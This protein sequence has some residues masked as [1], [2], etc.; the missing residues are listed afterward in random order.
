MGIE[1]NSRSRAIPAQS[2]LWT[3]LWVDL[4]GFGLWIG[5]VKEGKDK[6]AD[7][8]NGGLVFLI[9]SDSVSTCMAVWFGTLFFIRIKL[10]LDKVLFKCCH[11]CFWFQ[12]EVILVP[13]TNDL[14]AGKVKQRNIWLPLKVVVIISGLLLIER[15]ILKETTK[16]IRKFTIFE[17]SHK[18]GL[19]QLY[20]VTNLENFVLFEQWVSVCIEIGSG[21]NS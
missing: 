20:E 10:F 21:K 13:T 5:R 17:L 12:G 4:G 11:I 7:M 2:S 8:E 15:N 1:R 6:E 14:T 18:D 19:V 3:H 9:W 16:R